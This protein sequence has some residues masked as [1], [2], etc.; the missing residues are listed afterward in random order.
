MP[1]L[2]AESLVQLFPEGFITHANLILLELCKTNTS[3]ESCDVPWVAS[4]LRNIKYALP[5]IPVNIQLE[6]DSSIIKVLP[7][8]NLEVSALL[9]SRFNPVA[10]AVLI[11][12][13]YDIVPVSIS[14]LIRLFILK[15]DQ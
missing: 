4:S 1:I 6:P 9:Y 2:F 3:N 14:L 5:D 10:Q 12:V 11:P 8:L 13:P 7:I 15:V